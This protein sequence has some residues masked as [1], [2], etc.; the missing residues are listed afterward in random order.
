[1]EKQKKT[2]TGRVLSNKMDKTVVV[3]VDT[4]KRHPLYRKTVRRV[5]KYKAHDENNACN[6]GDTVR[7]IETRPLSRE[8]RWRVSEIIKR[9]DTVELK[10]EEV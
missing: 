8:K 2:R 6:E 10:P 7:I 1:M 5:I 4:S 3:G 9:K